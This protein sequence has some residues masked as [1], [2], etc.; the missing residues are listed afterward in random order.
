MRCPIHVPVEMRR[1][2][3]KRKRVTSAMYMRSAGTRVIYRCP[4]QGCSRVR[5]QDDA[6]NE[7]L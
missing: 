7:E 6:E 4:V 3:Q 1:E 2:V 5:M